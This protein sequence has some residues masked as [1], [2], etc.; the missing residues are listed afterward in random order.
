MIYSQNILFLVR[1]IG[2]R[3]KGPRF[4][5]APKL[6]LS[7]SQG[8]SLLPYAHRP[9]QPMSA[10]QTGRVLKIR[11]TFKGGIY[12]GYVGVIIGVYWDT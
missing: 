8:E 4:W 6:L 1:I 3:R 12:G 5:A 11:G 2:A 10:S 7:A 9:A